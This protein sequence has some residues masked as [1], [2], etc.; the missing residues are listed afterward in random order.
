MRLVLLT[1]FESSQVARV[2]PTFAREPVNGQALRLAKGFEYRPVE[3][4]SGGNGHGR[5]LRADCPLAQL[6]TVPILSYNELLEQRKVACHTV[7]N[8]CRYRTEDG[9]ICSVTAQKI[10]LADAIRARRRE[11]G[12]TQAEL[13]SRTDVIAVQTL[14]GIEQGRKA[15]KRRPSAWNALARALGWDPEESYRV[16]TTESSMPPVRHAPVVQAS[17]TLS[18]GSNTTSSEFFQLPLRVRTELRGHES[19]DYRIVELDEGDNSAKMLVMVT[20]DASDTDVEKLYQ[21]LRTWRQRH[22]AIE[23]AISPDDE[24]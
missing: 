17:A 2:D 21:K 11:L 7:R 23:R 13:A 3:W 18:A 15:L 5:T 16:I 24:E 9:K 8:R 6:G 14:R 12:L 20:A 19:W 1:Q 10:T 22:D 4:G